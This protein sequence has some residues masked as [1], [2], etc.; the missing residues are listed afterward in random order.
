MRRVRQPPPVP[1]LEEEPEP[2]EV[3]PVPQLPISATVS[4]ETPAEDTTQV[5]GPSSP[6]DGPIM[7]FL[8]VG[9]Q[10][11]KVTVD[12]GLSF[13]S[14][15]VLFMDRFSYNPGQDNFPEIYIR[16]PS[17]GVQYELEDIS[18]VKNKCL[19]SLNIERGLMSIC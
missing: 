15:R 3:P 4:A 14:L 6:A 5:A 12:A 8:Q 18:E 1:A 10:V 13:S 19:L 2:S 9:R 17:S 11:K 16:D 7:V